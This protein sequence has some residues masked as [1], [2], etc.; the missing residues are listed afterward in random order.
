MARTG[1]WLFALF[2]VTLGG[3]WVVEWTGSLAQGN[4]LMSW[5][6]F[7]LPVLGLALP[8]GRARG[9]CILGC[10]AWLVMAWAVMSWH[11]VAGFHWTVHPE[12]G[13]ILRLALDRPATVEGVALG[14]G[15][16]SISRPGVARWGAPADPLDTTEYG[17]T[18]RVTFRD[19][20]AVRV[21]G[22]SLEQDRRILLRSGDA[23]AQLRYLFP[24]PSLE[25]VALRQFTPAGNYA[26][27]VDGA[28]VRRIVL[29][30]PGLDLWDLPP[31]ASLD[32]V[33]LYTPRTE[34]ERVLTKPLHFGELFNTPKRPDSVITSGRV[35]VRY[36]Q[37]PWLLY[38]DQDRVVGLL[39]RS[40]QIDGKAPVAIPPLT[41]QR[42]RRLVDDGGFTIGYV[43]TAADFELPFQDGMLA[44]MAFPGS[45]IRENDP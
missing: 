45:N 26:V 21:E 34:V 37:Y 43:L 16:S 40:L 38:D 5:L 35:V 44:R 4:Q 6:F 39:G 24:A 14:Q 2:L 3:C 36:P 10:G 19:N 22:A 42:L 31:V 12:A 27:T 23:R 17:P 33:S 32:G 8:T 30:A 13:P 29:L 25:G 15:R 20:V 18:L 11:L 9:G 28:K 41:G 7:G 1:C